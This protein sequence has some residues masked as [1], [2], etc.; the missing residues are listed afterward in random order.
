[1]NGTKTTTFRVSTVQPYTRGEKV[2]LTIG[3]TKADAKEL[4]PAT[5]QEVYSRRLSEL[6]E[7]DFR[8]ESPDCKLPEATRLV[9]S[10]IYN[11]VLNNDDAI[12]VVKFSHGK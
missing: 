10:G 3:W 6:Q 1:M 5:I 9:L 11:K 12:W 7:Y 2:M 4:H 8:G